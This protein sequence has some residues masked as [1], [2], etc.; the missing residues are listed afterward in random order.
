[1]SC[2][3]LTLEDRAGNGLQD[4]NRLC[5]KYAGESRPIRSGIVQTTMR[6]MQQPRRLK[7]CR[8]LVPLPYRRVSV[9]SYRGAMTEEAIRGYFLGREAYRRTDFIVLHD[10]NWRCAVIA[11]ERARTDRIDETPSALFSEIIKV[12]VLALPAAC[13]F[14][15]EPTADVG[16]RSALAAL[17][18]RYA[19]E[20]IQTLVV[21]G[22]YDHVNF[23]HNSDPAVV[24]VVEVVPP[25]PA[26]LFEM[27][28]Q[29]LSYADLPPIRLELEDVDVQA[30]C[31]TRRAQAYLLP[32]RSGG[33][34]NLDGAAYF[35]DERPTERRDWV[36]IGCERSLQFY[37]HY[38]RTEPVAVVD[39]CPRRLMGTRR[40]LTL[41]KCCLLEFGVERDGRSTVVVPWGANLAMVEQALRQ[42]SCEVEYHV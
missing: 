3:E 29:V 30:L 39:I 4:V 42:L 33:L 35:L 25:R 27:A 6:S 1:L 18:H 15:R 36:L 9:Q 23:I 5:R 16:N 20:P 21:W 2:S 7:D 8:N 11:I 41:V 14:V 26:K 19:A 12:E 13:K 22:K 37:H 32:C 38:Y 24:R 28:Q 17:A 34:E 31:E 40:G 10:E